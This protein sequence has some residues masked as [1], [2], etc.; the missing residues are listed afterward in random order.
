MALGPFAI[1]LPRLFFMLGVL[2]AMLAAH[3]WERRGGSPIDKPLWLSVLAGLIAAKLGYA[4]GHWPDYR[5]EP[6]TALYLWQPGYSPLAGLL[7]AAALL[8]GF[9][10]RRRY[11]AKGLLTP[12]IAGLSVWAGL[13]W[14]TLSL[15][16]AT[17]QPLP[18]LVLADLN[19]RPV[20][21][22]EYRGQPVVLN[23]WAS[24]CPPCRR[25]MPV[26][27]E[28]QQNYPHVHFVFANQGE[29]TATVRRFL[30]TQTLELRNVLSDPGGQAGR[31]FRAPG[32]PTTLFFDAD[33]QLRASHMGELTRAVLGDQLRR[34]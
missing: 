11:P 28:A 16:Q 15:Q 30:S 20:S 4:L 14:V 26:L 19:G 7:V 21:L 25:E 24:W 10:L 22:A 31:H 17:D 8:A 33:G 34:R 23:L 18:D 27:A 1:A 29:D 9:I 6:L 2:A 5:A 32:L 13:S 3:L 12:V